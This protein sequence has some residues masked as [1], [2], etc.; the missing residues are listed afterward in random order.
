MGTE[1]TLIYVTSGTGN[2]LR[3]AR[4]VAE[5]LERG[6][7]DPVAVVP[8]ERARPAEE[9]DPGGGQELVLVAPTH[10]FTTPWHMLRFAVSLPRGRG[11]RAWVLI[12]RAGI[13]FGPL[14]APGIGASNTFL[15]ALIL[16]LKGFRV[17]GVTGVDM[18]SNW[19]SLHPIQSLPSQ[20][21]ILG[22][23]EGAVRRFADRMLAGDSAWLS[24]GNAAEAVCAAALL[25]VSFLYLFWGR[26]FLAKL[27]FANG[28]C[29]GCGV[30]E[31]ACPVGAIRMWGTKTR[32]PYWRFRCESCMRC[33]ALC[34]KGAVE[35]GHSWGVALYFLTTV[36]AT[37]LA[38]GSRPLERVAVLPAMMAVVFASYVLFH[39]LNRLRPVNW[40][41]SRTTLTHY[42]GRYREPGTSRA[43]LSLGH[44]ERGASAPGLADGRWTEEPGT[45]P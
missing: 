6:G 28:S 8:I 42:W 33:G 14:F 19:F 1:K 24:P 37:L 44:R 20:L 40:L 31:R 30:C 3:V 17:R 4:W 39:L 36:P 26:F 7:R 22:R 23:A 5:H 25:P 18:P 27:F 29:N 35:A 38:L 41:F 15:L 11:D 13:K 21:A 12:T 43:E 10:G 32:R 34:P 45:P 9:F 16:W 2:S